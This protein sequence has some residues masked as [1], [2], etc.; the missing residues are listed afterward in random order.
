MEIKS[1]MQKPKAKTEKDWCNCLL[2]ARCPRVRDLHL[3]YCYLTPSIFFCFFAQAS[4]AAAPAATAAAA[5]AAAAAASTFTMML[6]VSCLAALG[7]W[8]DG[9]WSCACRSSCQHPSGTLGPARSST[10]GF[11]I[12]HLT[13]T[14]ASAVAWN[15]GW[16]HGQNSDDP[17]LPPPMQPFCE[18]TLLLCS[19]NDQSLAHP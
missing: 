10:P 5:A 2:C 14:L 7:G 8:E 15:T 9:A 6:P 3:H 12:P 16:L 18:G 11:V 13:K 1:C 17:Q 4:F 19:S